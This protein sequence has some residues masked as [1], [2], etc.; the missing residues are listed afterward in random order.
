MRSEA[1]HQ[2]KSRVPA[3]AVLRLWKW[4]KDRET[5]VA[6]EPL[7]QETVDLNSRSRADSQAAVDPGGGTGLCSFYPFLNVTV[8]DTYYLEIRGSSRF[9]C[10]GSDGTTDLYPGGAMWM[11]GRE[12][13]A[14][15]L[16]FVTYTLSP[17]GSTYT[18]R[19]EAKPRPVS[20]RG[21]PRE[22]FDLGEHQVPD[23]LVLRS[24]YEGSDLNAVFNLIA[25]EYGHG[26][27]GAASLVSLTDGGSLILGQAGSPYWFFESLQDQDDTMAVC[28]R[29]WGGRY[30]AP[31]DRT[32]VSRFTDYRRA[33]VAWIE[34]ENLHGW[35]VDQE[36]RFYFVKNRF[37][38]I[39]DRFTLPEPMKASVGTVWH[40][41]DVRSRSNPADPA[42][43]D[44]GSNWY[45][46]YFREP[47][48]NIFKFRNLERYALL[49]FVPR[50][51]FEVAEFK[52]EAYTPPGCIETPPCKDVA[53]E[54][55]TSPPYVVYQ[56]KI[57]QALRGET[58]WFDTLILPHGR[59]VTPSIAAANVR[60]LYDDGTAV[61]LEIV[62]GNETWTVVDNPRRI[63]ISTTDLRT[64]A[65][66]MITRS[67]PGSADYV[68]TQDA[69]DLRTRTVRR[70]WAVK[71][72]V[73][74]GGG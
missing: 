6:Q 10:A 21:S 73:E 30:G 47:L 12:Q 64:D 74:S 56:R 61:G 37:L 23:K 49:Y 22:Y 7:Y 55:R 59:D 43:P 31:G 14:A 54:C 63:S 62:V 34:W 36:R 48:V 72:S 19:L 41:A 13:P 65:S 25:G 50:P 29:Y 24:G 66:Y 15:D 68:L 38:L 18:T 5:T 53:G 71:T 45:D 28:K 9:F 57:T 33:T 52:E 42:D 1:A 67:R 32:R 8:G 69:K 44:H 20:L 70:T 11:T 4:S 60:V 2:K 16:W 35:R 51:A 40:A 39:R 3:A 46:V 26:R 17:N 27:A 58:D